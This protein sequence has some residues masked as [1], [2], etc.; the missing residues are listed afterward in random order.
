MFFNQYFRNYSAMKKLSEYE[1]N[2]VF[3]KFS[4]S[5]FKHFTEYKAVSLNFMDSVHQISRVKIICV[6]I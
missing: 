2:N 6:I 4:N 3:E 1:T 5:S